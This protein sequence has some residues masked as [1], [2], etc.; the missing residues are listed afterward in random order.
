MLRRLARL[1]LI[2]AL[3]F[4]SLPYAAVAQTSVQDAS[5]VPFEP[6]PAEVSIT[7]PTA[8]P[9]ETLTNTEPVHSAEFEGNTPAG[10]YSS[11]PV[12]PRD[13][14]YFTVYRISRASL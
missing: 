4:S 8:A 7:E 10:L 12:Y 11:T 2:L 1:L 14:V 13:D 6:L 3:L 9:S 5:P